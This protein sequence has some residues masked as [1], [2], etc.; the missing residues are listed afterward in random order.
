MWTAGRDQL[1]K[2]RKIHK[3]CVVLLYEYDRLSKSL[4]S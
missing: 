1:L 2:I 3:R 4:L